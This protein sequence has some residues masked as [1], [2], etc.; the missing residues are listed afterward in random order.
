M[1]GL[2]PFASISDGPLPYPGLPRR[3]LR[4]I[5][6]GCPIGVGSRVLDVG[7]GSGELLRFLY[8]LCL[9]VSG[10]DDSQENVRASR[11]ISPAG[12]GGR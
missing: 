11:S 1:D 6:E 5:F 2:F 9:D 12:G 8:Q 10:L 7:C 4:H 3:L